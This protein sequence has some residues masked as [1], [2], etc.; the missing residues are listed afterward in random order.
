LSWIIVFSAP[1]PEVLVSDPNFL[2]VSADELLR[3]VSLATYN[4]RF[5]KP[6]AD[7]GQLP[8]RDQEALLCT[9]DAFLDRAKAG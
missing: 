2:D 8:K 9:I 1:I 5:I 4:R 3:I 6:N 7:D